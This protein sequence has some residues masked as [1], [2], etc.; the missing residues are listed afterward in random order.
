MGFVQLCLGFV[1]LGLR[2]AVHFP[3]PYRR[4]TV[5]HLLHSLRHRADDRFIPF[6]EAVDALGLVDDDLH[7]HEAVFQG[8]H[9]KGGLFHHDVERIR[10]AYAG[11]IRV[12]GNAHDREAIV[13][14]KR[15]RLA[16]RVLRH[17]SV[18]HAPAHVLGKPLLHDA[19][20]R[21]LRHAAFDQLR[22]IHPVR[23]GNDADILP[24]VPGGGLRAGLPYGLRVPDA[25][26]VHYRVKILLVKHV[27][28]HDLQVA[29]VDGIIHGG[30]VLA[31]RAVG[32]IDAQEGRHAEK[33]DDDDR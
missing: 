6:A 25:L 17:H 10:Y 24:L 27:G 21:R 4:A 28:G 20:L 11:V 18:A 14:Q 30:A 23:Q 9:V 7:L 32:I 8:L 16:L 3:V 13:L 29:V 33:G 22:L 19:L 12:I 2:L 31:Q 26:H 15:G 1:Q 5:A